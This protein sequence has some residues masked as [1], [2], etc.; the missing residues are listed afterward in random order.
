MLSLFISVARFCRLPLIGLTEVI[1]YVGAAS[2]NAGGSW[3]PLLLAFAVGLALHLTVFI[4]NDVIDAEIDR[5]DP[6]RAHTPI[7]AG[8]IGERT[9]LLISLASSVVGAVALLAARDPAKPLVFYGAATVGFVVYDIYG[10]RFVLPPVMDVIQGLAWAS[11][12]LMSASLNGEI[13]IASILLA[14]SICLYICVLN[15]IIG[16]LRDAA[17]DISHHAI[18]TAAFFL[19][20][21]LRN[22]GDGL[23]R[24]YIWY[25]VALEILHA[26]ACVAGVCAL[27]VQMGRGIEMYAAT[28]ISAGVF[29]IL[30]LAGALTQY[31]QRRLVWVC[32][33]VYSILAFWA[34]VV[35][36]WVGFGPTAFA[37]ASALLILPWL[38]S[39]VVRS[40]L[41]GRGD[42][43]H[44]TGPYVLIGKE[45]GKPGS[46]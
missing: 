1:V 38:G 23:P 2:G 41:T 26:V 13:G 33:F 11:L 12:A 10:K 20:G 3:Q 37:A 36:V 32:G 7:A 9:A 8:Q 34:I 29:C 16:S 45:Q 40:L 21:R 18:T 19:K 6:R 31:S 43:S 44:S 30:L 4:L 39:S 17:N 25:G 42:W 35:A 5:T 24:V 22:A 46:V 27:A 14:V 15:G 28:S